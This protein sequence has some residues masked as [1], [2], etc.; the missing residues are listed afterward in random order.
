VD[1]TFA[2]PTFLRRDVKNLNEKHLIFATDR[3]LSLLCKARTWYMDGT[4]K[5]VKKPFLQLYSIHAFI[6]CGSCVKQVP[7]A[8]ILMSC[9]K[10][11]DYE[12]VFTE[13]LEILPQPNRV[14]E[15][16]MDFEKAA[17]Q[18]VFSIFPT[19]HIQGCAFHWSRAAWHKT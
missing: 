18:A 5:L 11:I 3:M 17:W 13:L 16:V 19:A 9:K 12:K 10:R 1:H 15:I 14:Q 2:P 4:F 8:F 7:L 6:K